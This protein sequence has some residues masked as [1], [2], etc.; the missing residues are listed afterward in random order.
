MANL[1]ITD[2]FPSLFSHERRERNVWFVVARLWMD[3]VNVRCSLL[4]EVEPTL[5]SSPS[6]LRFDRTLTSAI[7]S[8]YYSVSTRPATNRDPS[9]FSHGF[10]LHNR[11]VSFESVN[12]TDGKGTKNYDSLFSLLFS[13]WVPSFSGYSQSSSESLLQWDWSSG[14]KGLCCQ[15]AK[16]KNSNSQSSFLVVIL[17]SWYVS[18]SIWWKNRKRSE[19]VICVQID[20]NLSVI[21]FGTQFHHCQNALNYL[22]QRSLWR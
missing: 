5:Q 1:R 4:K 13:F 17:Y 10:R 19:C 21:C 20:N 16:G 11:E 2:P 6:L 8:L 12:R 22:S 18:K 15:G 7:D 9:F 14:R 3:W